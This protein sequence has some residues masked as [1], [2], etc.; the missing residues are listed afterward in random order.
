MTNFAVTAQYPVFTDLDGTPLENGYIYIG[1]ENENPITYPINV[2]WDDAL[3]YTAGQPI[4]T[5]AGA[6][7][8]NGSPSPIFVPGNFSILVRDKNQNQVYY[9][10]SGVKNYTTGIET[11]Y[12]YIQNPNFEV[13][14]KFNGT[15]DRWIKDSSGYTLTETLI[16]L[17]YNQTVI[18]SKPRYFKKLSVSGGLGAS[19]YARYIQVMEDV[20]K[21]AGE[22]ITLSFWGYVD[23]GL[24]QIAVSLDQVGSF[25]PSTAL[26][27][28]I[29]TK[30]FSMTADPRQ[31]SMT[32]NVPSLFGGGSEGLL[33]T[34]D[35]GLQVNLWLGAGS[36]Y[37][38][39]TESLGHG[40]GELY[41]TN[42]RLNAGSQIDTSV[43][44]PFSEELLLCERY[45][46]K[47]GQDLYQPGQGNDDGSINYIASDTSTTLPGFKYRTRKRTASPTVTVY[48][49]D[50]NNQSDLVYRIGTGQVA[51]SSYNGINDTGISTMTLGAAK[52]AGDIYQYHY[53][54]DAEF[55]I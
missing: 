27:S 5:L 50:A 26:N 43:N 42:V 19:E 44:R 22:K 52:V 8:R 4:R 45:V 47:S 38:D 39:Q 1:Q 53:V 51:V 12:N 20:Y 40:S 34:R 25:N 41:F 49:P 30:K 11:G 29:A 28:A 31:Y 6:P 2:Y 18:P 48:S 9:S 16:I 23:G 46:E 54:V 32:I 3:S 24:T 15:S 36:D 14:Q 17:S 21:T 13:M 55:I 10:R 37:D 7:N 33:D 35:T